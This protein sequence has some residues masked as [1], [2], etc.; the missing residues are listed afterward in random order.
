MRFPLALALLVVIPAAALALWGQFTPLLRLQSW[1]LAAGAL[2]GVLIEQQ[3]HHRAPVIGTFTHELAHAFAALLCFRRVTGFVVT[4][5]RGGL[6]RPKGGFGGSCADDFIG[7]APYLFPTLTVITVAGRP[8]APPN[9]FPWF[10]IWLGTTIGFHAFSSLRDIPH[11]W[12]RSP[13]RSAAGDIVHTDL[14][15]P[16]VVY[17]LI[18]IAAAAL[19]V[20]GLMLAVYGHGYRGAYRWAHDAW[21]HTLAVVSLLYAYAAIAWRFLRQTVR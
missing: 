13:F 12:S 4:R 5:R 6:V 8:W 14:G 3:I 17:S 9:W 10:D 20:Y 1:P 18:F 15:R 11:N 16:G 7:L 19:A 21:T 2:A